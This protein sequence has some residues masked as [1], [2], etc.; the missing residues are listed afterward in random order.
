MTPA[1]D[2]S[3]NRS[4]KA[5]SLQLYLERLIRNDGPISVA[6][7][8]ACALH[9]PLLGY[10]SKRDPLGRGGDFTTAPEVSQMFGELIG[11]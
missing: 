7:F 6:D 11:L 1:Q 10:Y 9:H 8:M 4:N 2:V 5:G 3:P